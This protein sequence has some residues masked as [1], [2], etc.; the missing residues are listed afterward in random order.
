M[1]AALAAPS[2]WYCVALRRVSAWLAGAAQRLEAPAIDRAVPPSR[3]ALGTI[4]FLSACDTAEERL[5]ELRTRY[6]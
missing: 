1:S 3:E 5:R 2:P 6:Y 4:E